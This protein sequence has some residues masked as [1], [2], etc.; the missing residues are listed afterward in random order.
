MGTGHHVVGLVTI[1][2]F[3]HGQYGLGGLA[4][5]DGGSNH[6]NYCPLEVPRAY[7]MGNGEN[8]GRHLD[9]LGGQVYL[10]AIKLV[11]DQGE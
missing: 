6:D 3:G 9:N 5:R 2:R 7:W 11:H 1:W 4:G 8:E 10:A